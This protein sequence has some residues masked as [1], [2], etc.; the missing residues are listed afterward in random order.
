MVRQAQK[1]EE[2]RHVSVF[3]KGTKIVRRETPVVEKK[4]KLVDERMLSKCITEEK[5]EE[6]FSCIVFI[7]GKIVRGVK[8]TCKSNI[9]VHSNKYRKGKQE[10][11]KSPETTE[12]SDFTLNSTI[13]YCYIYRKLNFSF[14][15]IPINCCV[16]TVNAVLV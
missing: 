2:R 14:L 1:R 11:Y 5:R 16:Y 6:S 15:C 7:K 4:G 10:G 9:V 3:L 8:L 12:R 13:L